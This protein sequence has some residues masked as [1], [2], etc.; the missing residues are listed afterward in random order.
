M[1]PS[2]KRFLQS[3]QFS[4]MCAERLRITEGKCEECQSTDNVRVFVSGGKK[5]FALCPV[6]FSQAVTSQRQAKPS[7]RQR[8]PSWVKKNRKIARADVERKAIAAMSGNTLKIIRS[9]PGVRSQG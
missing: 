6:H 4:A 3:D 8:L 2:E 5:L 7:R 9:T 1:T